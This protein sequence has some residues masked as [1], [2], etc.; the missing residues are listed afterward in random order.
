MS[1]P[2]GPPAPTPEETEGVPILVPP[3]PGGS[4]LVEYA[5][6]P[7]PRP[8]ANRETDA[9]TALKRGLKEYLE[10]VHLDVYGVRIRFEQVHDVWA[11]TDQVATFPSAAIMAVDEA[12]YD[13]SSFTPTLNPD[14]QVVLGSE[15]SDT[16]SYLVKYA[17]V[18]VRLAC[19][20]HCSSTDERVAV[21]MMLEDALNPVDFMYGFM[22]DLPHYYNQRAVFEPVTTQ[23]MDSDSSARRRWRPGTVFLTG[24][25]SLLRVRSLPQFRP[26]TLV[27]VEGS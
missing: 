3:A 25:I 12:E 26:K 27:V 1:D 11:N 17:E 13:Y 18:A 7:R 6:K 15:P 19:E 23:M 8:T 2:C 9:V 20:V 14:M 16:K 10:Q 21:A 24:Q 5:R 22:L 4:T